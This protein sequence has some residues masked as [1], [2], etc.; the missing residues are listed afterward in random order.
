MVIVLI[1]GGVWLR[2][3]KP[4]QLPATASA[5]VLTVPASITLTGKIRAAHVTSV[6]TA[7][8]GTI[9]SFEASVG[10]EV[11][12]GQVLARIGSQGLESAR[13]EAADAVQKA[14]N[15]VEA[16]EKTVT[17]AQLEASRAHA[18]AERSRAELDRVQKIFDRQKTLSAAGATPRLTYEKAERDYGR[19]REEWEAVSKAD[20][21][22]TEHVQDSLRA[23]DGVRRVLLDKNKELEDAEADAASA[24]VE[25]PV[26]GLIVGRNGELGQRIEEVGKDL[27]QIATDLYDLEA[28][29]DAKPDLR[30]RIRSGEPVLVVIPDLQ[31]TGYSGTVKAIQD[32]QVVASFQSPT[33]A[34]RPG[35]VAEIRLKPQ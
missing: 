15:R 9:D 22:A 10:D 32:E 31:G 23:L 8:L 7:A 20:R 3:R 6:D 30:K 12:Q 21:L 16:A 18:D 24:V 34:I 35:M 14:Q 27:F 26:D 5:S 19:A 29:A 1:G 25:A 28:V 2:H 4:P 33:P 11:Y 17:A 13:T